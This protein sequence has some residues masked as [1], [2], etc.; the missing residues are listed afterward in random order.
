[1][2][3]IDVLKLIAMLVPIIYS[4]SGVDNSF[5]AINFLAALSH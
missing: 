4:M 3:I 2:T 5:R 1:M